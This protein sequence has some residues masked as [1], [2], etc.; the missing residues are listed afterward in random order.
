MALTS[1]ILA[2]KPNT[3]ELK[4][5]RGEE[6]FNRI[7]PEWDEFVAKLAPTPLPLT[8]GWLLAWWK[9]FAVDMEMEFRCVYRN[10]ALVGIAPLIRTRERYRGV[11]ITLLKLAAN[12]HSPYSSVI[13]DSAL[14]PSETEEVYSALTQISSKEVGL[15]FKID[16][17]S[18]LKRFLTDRSKPGH[19]RV[20]EKPS[21]RTPVI[22][23]DGSWKEFY[24]SR[25]RSL[26]KSL[27]HK[28][29][30]FRNDGDFTID[31]E[32]ITG[33]DQPIIDELI[34]I[35]ANSW[36]ASI[37]N[38]LRSN[39]RSRHFLLNLVGTF[40]KS[41]DLS[42]WIVRHKTTP[43]AFEVHLTFDNVVYPIRAD[44]DERFKAYSPG[45][46]LEYSA[47]KDLFEQGLYRQYY[48]C[49]DDYWYLSKWTSDYRSFCSVELF[50]DSLKLR[51]IYFVERRV[52]PV[53]KRLIR[54]TK[55]R[56]RTA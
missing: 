40:G 53:I 27:N 38:D 11:P 5:I 20:L 18:E 47:L 12:G 30:R 51:A 4:R 29:N 15:F 13:V 7:Q 32:M 19:E 50:G 3:V 33:A 43:V 44:Y 46:V 34:A 49:A 16:Q 48:T 6:E 24:Q 41:G 10:E 17:T 36:K 8:H 23:I 37:G 1:Y 42:A 35:S 2:G 22:D 55:T 39:Q 52:I 9:A 45:S 26:K 31:H 56:P 54:S 28:L 14:T 25:S 21:L